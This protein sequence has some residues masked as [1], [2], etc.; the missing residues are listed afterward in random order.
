[1]RQ[2]LGIS[3][4]YNK[5]SNKEYF[6]ILYYM[7]TLIPLFIYHFIDNNSSFSKLNVDQSVK[8]NINL[9][10]YKS[11]INIDLLQSF[12]YLL[13]FFIVMVSLVKI[14][15]NKDYSYLSLL[16]FGL[17]YYSGFIYFKSLYYSYAILIF[18]HGIPYI[19]IMENRI[20]KTH[21]S[22]LFR[23]NSLIIIC[24]F[25][26]IGVLIES[27]NG[28]ISSKNF[29]LN[30]IILALFWTPTIAHFTLDSEMWKHTNDKFKNMIKSNKDN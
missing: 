17:V 8:M 3:I 10:S 27:Q 5:D 28:S 15:K 1:M 22:S 13:I 11:L 21:T 12:Y 18:S 14:I 19:F 24:C 9:L 6:K 16:F 25:I 20:K 2:G 23:N 29:I 4:Q 26:I 30:A 7:S